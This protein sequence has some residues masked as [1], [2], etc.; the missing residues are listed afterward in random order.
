M[1]DDAAGG[2]P[3][4]PIEER[5]PTAGEDPE[6]EIWEPRMPAPEPVPER[7]A[8]SFPGLGNPTRIW[9]YRDTEGRPLFFTARFEPKNA[10]GSPVLGKDGKPEKDVVPYVYG[11]RVWTTR[12]GKRLDRT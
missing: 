3:F 4:A 8:L 7:S 9:V 10:D 5:L 11:R 1:L 12:A 2:N 6:P